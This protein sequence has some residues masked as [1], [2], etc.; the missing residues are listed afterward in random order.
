M[1][2][3]TAFRASL[4]LLLLAASACTGSVAVAP[5]TSTTTGTGGVATSTGGSGGGLA[6]MP[7][8]TQ[9][10]ACPAGGSGVATCDASG[11]GFGVCSGCDVAWSKRFEDAWTP[12]IGP[13]DRVFLATR[14]SDPGI[15]GHV[16]LIDPAGDVVQD[17]PN[18]P[19]LRA[20]ATS[21]GAAIFAGVSSDGGAFGE[22]VFES[23]LRFDTARIEADGS[24]AIPMHEYTVADLGLSPSW[25]PMWAWPGTGVGEDGRVAVD[26]GVHF[27]GDQSTT[28]RGRE[29]VV[30]SAKGELLWSRFILAWP[31]A[32]VGGGVAMTPQGDVIAGAPFA[33]TLD[34]GAGPE[35]NIV[36]GP[37]A[38]NAYVVRYSASGDVLFHRQLAASSETSIDWVAV[39]ADLDGNAVLAVG[40]TGPID[41]GDGAVGTPG[42]RGSWLAKLGPGGEV[43]WHRAIDVSGATAVGPDGSIWICGGLPQGGTLDGQPAAVAGASDVLLSRYDASGA[44]I[45]HHQWGGPGAD[46]CQE[47]TVGASGVPVIMGAFQDTIDFGQGPLT[48][49]NDTDAF[50]AKLGP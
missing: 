7:G 43:L 46:H 11:S 6:C 25:L 49:Q 4:G 20:T 15:P 50:V 5:G 31:Y 27:P 16:L 42:V 40:A 18:A 33:H 30:L 13:D 8:A 32:D 14:T 24:T 22:G 10:C 34:V 21:G 48:A 23:V 9:P 41:F 44:T 29:V 45:S 47:L 39:A 37:P 12:V 35:P 2:L 26:V 1:K 3:T 17:Q 19:Q 36:D 28:M 38:F